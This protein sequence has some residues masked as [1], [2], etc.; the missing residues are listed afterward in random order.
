MRNLKILFLC[1]AF[2]VYAGESD[3]KQAWSAAAG[4]GKKGQ[5]A[6]AA[7]LYGVA[8]SA[9][10]GA[11]IPAEFFFD[12]GDALSGAG[13]NK[14]AIEQFE[15]AF[16]FATLKRPDLAAYNI[17]CAQAKLGDLDMARYSLQW[18]V[19]LGY[20]N[21]AHLESDSDLA[22][23]RSRSDWPALIKAL[24]AKKTDS[25]IV[26]PDFLKNLAEMKGALKSG[27]ESELA[28]WVNIQGGT[29]YNKRRL[30]GAITQIRDL[31]HKTPIKIDGTPAVLS[32]YCRK[33]QC[34]IRVEERAAGGGGSNFEYTFDNLDNP[35][36]GAYRL[37]QY[38]CSGGCDP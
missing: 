3:F 11:E 13:K 15:M 16:S 5:W 19:Y 18:A 10:S 21:M 34:G 26:D 7:R 35:I 8:L 32:G 31:G 6:E 1:L 9:N 30:L 12:Y 20:K 37:K 38:E 14:E 23:L 24:K 17:A 27:K 2:T 22:K 33:W 25:G 29:S 36:P 28:K 4:A